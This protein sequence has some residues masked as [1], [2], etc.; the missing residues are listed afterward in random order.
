MML[1]MECDFWNL[2]YYQMCILMCRDQGMLMHYVHLLIHLQNFGKG[3]FHF[4]YR[5]RKQNGHF[6]WLWLKYKEYQQ[7]KTLSSPANNL[8]IFKREII[9][10][11]YINFKLNYYLKHRIES[12]TLDVLNTT[13]L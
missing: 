1:A 8:A 5:I 4:G 13:I 2:S 7:E 9:F 3:L 12:N 6:H 10:L 11:P